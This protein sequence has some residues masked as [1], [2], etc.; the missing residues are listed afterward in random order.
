VPGAAVAVTVKDE[1]LN[2]PLETVQ[3]TGVTTLVGL[4]EM[5]QVVSAA[6]NPLP[7]T[8]TAVPAG[9]AL[10]VRVIAGVGVVTVKVAVA[11]SPVGLPRTLT[12]YVPGVAVEATTKLGLF[13]CPV[14]EMVHGDTV[15]IRTGEAGAADIVQATDESA[16]AKPPPLIT[17]L[18]PM[19][20][21]D[22][23]SPIMGVVLVTVK[24]VVATSPPLPVTIIV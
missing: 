3:P 13:N 6:A 20:P 16:E 23:E 18:V 10:G 1:A 22:G 19:G 8:L 15:I 4:L 12:V 24:E 14:T 9:P 7:V 17:T 11:K 2:F 21:E 5:T